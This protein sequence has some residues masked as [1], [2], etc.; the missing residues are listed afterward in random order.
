MQDIFI[1]RLQ[2]VLPTYKVEQDT[3]IAWLTAALQ[4]I[5]RERQQDYGRAVQLY[6]RLMPRKTILSRHTFLADYT[7]HNWDQMQLFA[8][9][10]GD[11]FPWYEPPL[12]L[13]MQLYEQFVD[14]A[15]QQA[16]AVGEDLPDY[17]VEVSCTGYG[18]PSPGQK[19]WQQM[20]P[21]TW[22]KMLRLGHMGCY[23]ALPAVNMGRALLRDVV[24]QKSTG[25]EFISIM[26]AE[27]CTL[28]LQPAATNPEQIVVN[29]L[30]ADGCIRIDLSPEATSGSLR[31]V[32]YAEC[33]LAGTL[34]HM[35]WNLS[36][37][38]FMM[39]LSPQIPKLLQQHLEPAVREFLARENLSLSDVSQLAV[40]PGGPRIIEVVAGALGKSECGVQHSLEVLQHHGNMSSA[41]L[42]HVWHKMAADAHIGRELILS[43]AFGP[44]LT[45]SMLLM[46]KIP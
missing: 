14:A 1:T 12:Q 39:T 32:A 6:Q 10:R 16:F 34:E 18:S 13:R 45:L 35:T 19:R 44:G 30:F 20:A 41:T 33:M 27:L 25:R 8:S 38:G 36:A 17:L 28:H 43:L 26:S 5:G 7:H 21:S 23:A 22:G 31:V 37:T 15:Y 4:R 29:S 11:A 24:Q 46:E 2:P 40:H 9:E 3:G 42:P